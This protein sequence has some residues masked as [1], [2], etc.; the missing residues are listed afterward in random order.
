MKSQI[1]IF[2][3]TLVRYYI[4]LGLFFYF[5]RIQVFGNTNIPKDK[6]F[7]L[8]SNHQNGLLDPLII[9]VTYN[10]FAYFLT[11]AAVFKKPVVSKLL[12]CFRMIPIYR[13]RDG[14]Q[15]LANNEG[16]FKQ[17][18]DLLEVGESIVI[19]PEGNHNLNRTVRS[20]SKGFTRII[21]G[22]HKTNPNLDL[23]LLPIGL[24]YASATQF[25]D[26]VAVFYGDVKSAKQFVSEDDHQTVLNLKQAIQNDLQDL[27]THIPAENYWSNLERLE[28]LGADFLNPKEVNNCISSD[29]NQCHFERKSSVSF[30]NKSF[31]QILKMVLF[32]PYLVWKLL[33]KPKIKEAEFISTFRFAL[34]ITL[35]PL[36]LFLVLLFCAFFYGVVLAISVV[37]S[38]CLIALLAVKA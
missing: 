21:V 34:A 5:K 13:V 8:L 7:L 22:A 16:V 17:C 28:R 9:A 37:T 12:K 26:C 35:V 6:P 4:Q 31:R 24:N 32:G 38:I 23:Q 19:F 36:W 2:G 33:V 18:F 1:S 14:W 10:R 29:F 15:T 11:R 25:P 3:L 20:L 30:V 27:T